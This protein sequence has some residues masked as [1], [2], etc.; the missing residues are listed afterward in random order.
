M[1]ETS[2]YPIQLIGKVSGICYGSNVIDPEKNKYKIDRMINVTENG[3]QGIDNYAGW[4]N[5]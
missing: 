1:D 3:L 4:S 5:L 2:S